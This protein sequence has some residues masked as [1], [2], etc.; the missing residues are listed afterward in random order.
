[1]R[2]GLAG[3]TW[4]LASSFADKGYSVHI[5]T[6]SQIEYSSDS[7]NIFIHPI[8]SR[9]SFLHIL[10]TFQFA[11][12][13]KPARV[14]VQYL[15]YIFG[16]RAGIN[17]G[18]PMAISLMRVVI[19]R[20]VDCIC[21]EL[22]YPLLP[23]PKSMFIHFCH[24]IM[25]FWVTANIH[26]IFASTDRFCRELERLFFWK[27]NRIFR[28]PVGS[29]IPIHS[30][31]ENEKNRLSSEYKLKGKV[32][33]MFGTFHPTTRVDI[34]LEAIQ[35]EFGDSDWSFVIIGET[36]T[37]LKERISQK[38]WNDVRDNIV[39]LGTVSEQEVSKWLQL[40]DLYIAYFSDGI[41]TR[42]G[43]LMAALVHGCPTVASESEF[44]EPEF[45]SLV[46][47]HLVPAS[48]PEFKEGLQKALSRLK[49]EGKAQSIDPK[50]FPFSWPAIVRIYW[51]AV[52]R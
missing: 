47:L 20:P 15:P 46:G 35:L 6:S 42:R 36:E 37:R 1:M 16:D 40:L 30:L 34:V 26:T 17:F 38:L 11:R 24:R 19:G 22:Y 10:S 50:M 18:A 48:E 27:K 28:L 45:R 51:Q 8:V 14:I 49:N 39:A 5:I 29:N 32:L 52:N 33:G 41:S 2:S 31:K 7:E 12:S 9:W 4:Q 25:L 21:H 13:L 23:D 43:S 3:H 44:T